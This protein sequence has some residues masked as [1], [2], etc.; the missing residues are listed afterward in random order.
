M[1]RYPG[2][3]DSTGEKEPG[4]EVNTTRTSLPTGVPLAGANRLVFE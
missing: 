3:T 2:G 1:I 4:Q